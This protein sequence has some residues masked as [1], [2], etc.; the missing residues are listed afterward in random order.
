MEAYILKRTLPQLLLLVLLVLAIITAA[1]AQ[2]TQTLAVS[3]ASTDSTSALSQT[4][5]AALAALPEADTL[6][7]INSRRILNE[8]APRLMPEKDLADLRKTFA[9]MKQF[10]GVDPSNVDYL[11]IA[12]RFRKPTAELT[13]MP[14]EFLA[15]ASGDFSSDSLMVLARMAS[16]GKLRDE[17]YGTKTLGLMTIDPIA[18]EAEKN[19]ILKS[20]SEV[21]IVPLNATTIAVGSTA[22]LKAAI[23]AEEG[24]K[25]ISSESLNSLLRDPGALMSIAGSPLTSFSKTFGLLGTEANA[26]APRCDSK[27]GDF[28]AALTM[29]ASN[30]ML[31]GALNADNSDTAKIINSLI[32]GLLRQATSS[33]LDP[34]AQSLFKALSITPQENEI[35]VRADVPQQMV[36]DIIKEQMKPKKKAEDSSVAPATKEPTTRKRPSRRRSRR[37]S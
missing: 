28:Y 12:V 30:F 19:P 26:R 2:T 36:L 6:I 11:V 31:R 37:S 13:F 33:V 24:N 27:F 34:A 8:A 4:V 29:D 1:Q 9:D 16:E 21:A 15:V 17:K 14:P 20:F 10:A 25:R 18:K 3:G 5:P 23:D 32:N 35:V 22:Y 7:F